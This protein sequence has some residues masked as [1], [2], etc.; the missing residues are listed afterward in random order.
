MIASVS[1]FILRFF[2]LIWF[3]RSATLQDCVS[4]ALLLKL[5]MVLLVVHQNSSFPCQCDPLNCPETNC[6]DADIDPCTCCPVC[7]KDVGERC[8]G[9]S[10]AEGSCGQDLTCALRPGSVLGREKA[11]ICEPG[12]LL[13]QPSSCCTVQ[14][15]LLGIQ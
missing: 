15:I 11:G 4:P 12:E 1:R 5:L 7:V 2:Q 13:S 10:N 9:R 3:A 8:G 6:T 14:H